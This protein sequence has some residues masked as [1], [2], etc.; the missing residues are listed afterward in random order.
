MSDPHQP[1]FNATQSQKAVDHGWLRLPAINIHVTGPVTIHAG[2]EQFQKTVLNHLSALH[3]QGE[4]LMATIDQVAQ[5]VSDESTLIDSVSTL[6][7]GLQQQIK[8][9]LSGATLP[10]D[11]Q[12]KV[13]A[14]FA[15]AEANKGKLTNAL[16]ANTPA[17]PVTPPAP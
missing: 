3:A 13:D 5:D 8:D 4:N 6:I 11:V 9:A 1:V 7:T 10:P 16:A 12:T 15:Q 14:V 17:A 2:D